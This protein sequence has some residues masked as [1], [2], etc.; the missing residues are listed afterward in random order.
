MFIYGKEFQKESDDEQT[1]VELIEEIEE[2]EELTEFKEINV[3]KMFDIKEADDLITDF[4]VTKEKDE[5]D[6]I[7]V[8][9][10]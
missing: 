9:V 7:L 5:E 2:D 6:K 1:F 10:T 8:V 4:V 3:A